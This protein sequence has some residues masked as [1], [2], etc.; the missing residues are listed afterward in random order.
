MATPIF[1]ARIRGLAYAT[2]AQRALWQ[3]VSGIF[4]ARLSEADKAV[5][6]GLF[7]AHMT[8]TKAFADAGVPMM[9]GS[10]Y[11][12]GWLLPGFSLHQE[13]DLLGEA[14]VT[15]LQ[16]LQMTTLNPATFLG[17]E[18][19][20]G[21]VSKGML[22]DLVL[23][24][25]NPLDDVQN[26]HGIGGIFKSGTYF[27]PEDIGDLLGREDGSG[28]PAPIPVPASLGLLV[29]GLGAVAAL[30]RRRRAAGGDVSDA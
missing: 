24:N 2:D 12:G 22:A 3:E 16:V 11:G 14:G 18:D 26:L 27:S 8:L 23:L 20:M 15:P 6:E 17:R 5:L 21:N 25:G 13:F 9:T 4:G 28:T 30:A 7:A 10:D 19:E 1:T 29:A